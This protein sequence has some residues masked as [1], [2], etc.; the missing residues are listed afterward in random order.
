MWYP[1]VRRKTMAMRLRHCEACGDAGMS[2]SDAC[3]WLCP[4]CDTKAAK[5]MNEVF[6]ICPKCHQQYEP[7]REPEAVCP[8]CK[9]EE[10]MLWC[11]KCDETAVR[12][13]WV[14]P[15]VS[16]PKCGEQWTGSY[17]P[18]RGELEAANDN[19]EDA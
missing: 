15:G 1:V 2:D 4:P 17:S 8:N 18:V 10:P 6:T 19:K 5:H 3:V 14:A 7:E 16:C 11:T 12:E 13:E 9:A